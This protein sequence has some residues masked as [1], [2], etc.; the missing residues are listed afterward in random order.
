MWIA[1]KQNASTTEKHL[2]VFDSDTGI[3]YYAKVKAKRTSITLEIEKL[4]RLGR[5]SA[6][7]LQGQAAIDFLQQLHQGLL[8]ENSAIAANKVGEFIQETMEYFESKLQ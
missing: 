4:D 1:V 5:G 8:R 2:I 6:F 3:F 7:P